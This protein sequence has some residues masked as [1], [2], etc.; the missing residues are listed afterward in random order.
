MKEN[1]ITVELASHTD[2]RGS[3]AYNDKLAQRRAESAVKYIVSKGI[4][5][6]RVIAKSYGEQK[7]INQCS[8]GVKCTAAEHQANRRTE[9]TVTGYIAPAVLP[10]Q[11]DPDQFKDGDMIDLKSLPEGFF[12]SCK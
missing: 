12:G 11:F 4:E 3:A 5:N 7:L 10:E 9:F 1:S 2:S 8:N 6:D